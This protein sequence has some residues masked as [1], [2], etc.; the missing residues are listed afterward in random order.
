MYVVSSLRISFVHSFMHLRATPSGLTELY[1]SHKAVWFSYFAH[2]YCDRYAVT[3]DPDMDDE[4]A[5][6][7]GAHPEL[8]SVKVYKSAIDCEGMQ[9]RYEK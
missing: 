8:K 6:I 9:V 1:H 3:R 2:L 4:V 5:K 7:L